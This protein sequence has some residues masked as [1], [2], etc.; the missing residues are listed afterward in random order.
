MAPVSPGTPPEFYFPTLIELDDEGG[1]VQNALEILCAA[2]FPSVSALGRERASRLVDQNV[3]KM[4][5]NE[6]HY[7]AC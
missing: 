4:I 3:Q 7:A 5:L 6:V 2:V 1:E